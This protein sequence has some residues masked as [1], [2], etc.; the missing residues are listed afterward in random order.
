MKHWRCFK[1]SQVRQSLQR[2]NGEYELVPPKT[3]LSRRTIVLPNFTIAALR[4][5]R[6]RQAFERTRAG[7]RWEGRDLVFTSPAGHP[8]HGP[9]VTRRFQ[10]LLADAGLERMRFHDLRH[11]CA[12]LLLAQGVPLSS[13][14]DVL[15]HSS[16]AT[17]R[18]IYAHL[19][20][21]LREEAAQAMDEA[22]AP[23]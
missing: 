11:S 20:D 10:Q 3:A 15:G 12:S 8:L 14:M 2:V 4:A 22:I 13:I 1:R 17:T 6:D 9:T 18:N 19:G 16:I 5:H 21:E 23:S 7:E